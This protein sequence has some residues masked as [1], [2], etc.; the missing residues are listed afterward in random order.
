MERPRAPS[1]EQ[2]D[3][4]EKERR[5]EKGRI[6]GATTDEIWQTF[7]GEGG[8]VISMECNMAAIWL[9]PFAYSHTLFLLY[10]VS[11]TLN[12]SLLPLHTHA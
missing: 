9:P 7:G 10:L 3:E 11:P 2:G 4:T 6:K 1:E 12:L 8:T 5:G